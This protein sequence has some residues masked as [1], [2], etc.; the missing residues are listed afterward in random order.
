MTV[1]AI[2]GNGLAIIGLA[3]AAQ[4]ASADTICS[5]CEYLDAD[6]G[7][8]VGSYNPNTTDNGTFT[9]TDIQQNVGA[10]TNFTNYWVFDIDPGGVGSIS[11]NF[12]TLTAVD[13]FA[14]SL[15]ALGTAT[16]DTATLP[17]SCS[18]VVTGS[19]IECGHHVDVAGS[20]NE[21][22]D[23]QH[24]RPTGRPIVAMLA[25]LLEGGVPA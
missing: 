8:W 16:C 24:G 3:L 25:G 19:Q 15:Y 11:A 14:G 13:N 6:A 22:G 17:D 2:V 10:S 12:T 21:G 1:R 7:T 18:T 5:G 9:H 20:A 23:W 4:G